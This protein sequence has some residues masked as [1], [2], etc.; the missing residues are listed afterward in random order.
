[1]VSQKMRSLS[2]TTTLLSWFLRLPPPVGSILVR[3][4]K[5]MPTAVT[6]SVSP[7]MTGLK[8]H[9]QMQSLEDDARQEETNMETCLTQSIWY[10]MG[11]KKTV[12]GRCTIETANADGNETSIPKYELQHCQSLAFLGRTAAP[13]PRPLH[14]S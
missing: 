1:M 5:F 13:K 7:R 4:G 12:R 10:L 14:N 3:A 8:D 11:Y 6:E 2:V 9:S